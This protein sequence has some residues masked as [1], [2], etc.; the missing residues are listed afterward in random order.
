MDLAEIC[1]ISQIYAQFRNPQTQK[2]PTSQQQCG[3]QIK[4][5]LIKSRAGLDASFLAHMRRLVLTTL[6]L[7][8]H[9]L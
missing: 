5:Q 7:N 6:I 8:K 1:S 4:K 2:H 3:V 9:Y